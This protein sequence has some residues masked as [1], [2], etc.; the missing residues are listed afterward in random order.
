MSPATKL[1][2]K[3]RDMQEVEQGLSYQKQEFQLKMESVKN[4]RQELKRK[5]NQLK[6][7]LVKFDKFLRENEAKMT[8]ALK[9]A[10]E[11]RRVRETKEQEIVKLRGHLTDLIR[12]RERQNRSLK[13]SKFSAV[14]QLAFFHRRNLSEI[15]GGSG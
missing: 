7:S 8:R 5:E 1:L 14:N 11:E 10:Q 12:K 2:E 6:E 4:R 9:K 13:R 15:F 3:R